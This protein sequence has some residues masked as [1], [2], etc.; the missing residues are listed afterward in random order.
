MNSSNE[1][2][3]GGVSECMSPE[4]KLGFMSIVL[5]ERQMVTHK[6]TVSIK[7]PRNEYVWFVSRKPKFFG[8][9]SLRTPS[10]LH[11]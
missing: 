2:V 3:R 7:G 6:V 11:T 1:V 10:D 8:S 4:G 5:H 9:R